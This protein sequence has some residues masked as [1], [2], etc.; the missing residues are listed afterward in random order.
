[1]KKQRVVDITGYLPNTHYLFLDE[2]LILSWCL[3]FP[4]MAHKSQGRW[5]QE[6]DTN[7]LAN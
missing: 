1:M 6:T 7:F 2:T 4:H 5:S 3:S